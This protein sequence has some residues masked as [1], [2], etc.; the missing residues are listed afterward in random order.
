LSGFIDKEL[1]ASIIEDMEIRF[2]QRKKEKIILTIEDDGIGFEPAMAQDT[3]HLGIFGIQERVEML[4]GS[5]NIESQP[6]QGTTIYIEVP[7][8]H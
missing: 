5:L 7:Y 1:C 4:G 3:E 2:I 6:N 8:G